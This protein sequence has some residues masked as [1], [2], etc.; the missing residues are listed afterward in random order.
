MKKFLQKIINNILLITRWR[1]LCIQ[2]FLNH[3]RT[4]R[5]K[6]MELQFATP[7]WICNF[8]A[9]TFATKEPETLD[10][11]DSFE[12]GSVF[13]DIGANV[14]VYSIYAGKKGA[15]V[16][17]FEPSFF[18]LEILARNV[19]LNG[20]ENN[21][22]IIPNALNYR[23]GFALMSHSN[24]AWCGAMSS[25]EQTHGQDGLTLDVVMQ[26]RTL[27]FSLDFAQIKLG[28]L[29]PDY[30]KIDVDGIEHLI[31]QG[32]KRCIR[33]AKAILIE[34]NEYFPEQFKNSTKIL[35]DS[36]FILEK[37]GKFVSDKNKVAN[38][39]WKRVSRKGSE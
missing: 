31:L 14:G 28:L 10:W 8:R 6:D 2:F 18:N 16:Y 12:K 27:G 15:L 38:Q 25:F 24:I 36:G 23:N 35:E 17:S 13:W 11:I 37:K 7:N 30:I 34:I 5:Y 29:E 22:S 26:Y 21:I 20:L 9:K 19:A 33:L 3:S 1:D 39:I 32:G 4:I